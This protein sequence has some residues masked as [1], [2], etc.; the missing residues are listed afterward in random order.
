MMR[1]FR[2]FLCIKAVDSKTEVTVRQDVPLPVANKKNKGADIMNLGELKKGGFIKQIQKD[3]FAVRLRLAGGNLALEQLE[4]INAIAAKYG[5]GYV[6]LTTR[7]G[8]EIPFIHFNNIEDVRRE[9]ADAN[10]G[11]GVC[12]G[13]VRGIMACQGTALCSHGLIDA[14]A[15]SA[16]IDTSFFGA[17]VPGKFKISVT[18]CPRSCAKPQE[19][20]LGFEGAVM[21]AFNSKTCI[22]CG[23][24]AQVC[25]TG[26]I[27]MENFFPVL[28]S[29]LCSRCGDCLSAC[30]TAAWQP[31]STGVKVW[32]GGRIGRDPKMGQVVLEFLPLEKISAVIEASLQF[33]RRHGKARER[34]GKTIERTGRELFRE[35]LKDAAQKD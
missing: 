9:L 17:E 21:P 5:S 19:N 25:P 11:L 29:E 34:F 35:V 16:Q 32:A 13:T 24:C 28:D 22:S 30:P 27:V 1:Y 14:K 7:Q 18:G 2:D 8:I 20:D 31:G 26:A 4:A 15:L 23:V 10:I 33:F 12:G 3:Y 6:H